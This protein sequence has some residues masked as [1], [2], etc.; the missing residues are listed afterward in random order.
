MSLSDRI[1]PLPSV[2]VA[3]IFVLLAGMTACRDDSPDDLPGHSQPMALSEVSESATL[4]LEFQFAAGEQSFFSE[5]DDCTA[6]D[7]VPFYDFDDRVQYFEVRGICDGDTPAQVIVGA[8][9]GNVPFVMAWSDG[10]SVYD[11]L[12]EQAAGEPF[13]VRFYSPF[14]II[15]EAVDS[16]KALAVIGNVDAEGLNEDYAAF[17]AEA[18]PPTA[19]TT[20]VSEAWDGLRQMA[21]AENDGPVLRQTAV[22]SNRISQATPRYDQEVYDGPYGGCYTGCGPVAAAILYGYWEERCFEDLIDGPWYD[23][24]THEDAD[25]RNMI[26]SLRSDLNSFCV[27]TWNSHDP[28]ATLPAMMDNMDEFGRDNGLPGMRVT[29]KIDIIAPY[30]YSRNKGVFEDHVRPQIDAGRPTVVLYHTNNGSFY[31]HYAVAEGYE[32]NSAGRYMEL[33]TGWGQNNLATVNISYGLAGSW[34]LYNNTDTCV[35]IGPV[36]EVVAPADGVTRQN[37][38][39]V[40]NGSATHRSQDSTALSYHWSSSLDGDISTEQS[41]S[42]RLSYGQHRITLQ[43]TDARGLSDNADVDITIE[44]E[45]PVAAIVSPGS[46]AVF[47]DGQTVEL[48]GSCSDPWDVDVLPSWRVVGDIGGV[49]TA[50]AETFSQ[51]LPIDD[52]T[53]TFTCTDEGQAFDTA[54]LDFEVQAEPANLPP[55]VTIVSPVHGTTFLYHSRTLADSI[56]F[57]ASADDSDGSI[58]S[59]S[60][61]AKRVGDS[62]DPVVFDSRNSFTLPLTDCS[63]PLGCP[64][65]LPLSFDISFTAVDNEGGTTTRTVRITIEYWVT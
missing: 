25:V 48:I 4:A 2:A 42:V 28:T 16:S 14:L 10:D 38:V 19:D 36:A 61:A 39:V 62:G 65:T 11:A 18:D 33:N 40:L 31:N 56:T 57:E 53:G 46:G 27:L 23:H 64:S 50:S 29:D 59:T 21:A 58:A 41:D 52:Y 17:L 15:G 44:N 45:D 34:S 3:A 32:I 20:H 7:A 22:T 30:V 1:L 8:N 54:S 47:Y 13:R 51:S 9:E 37:P 43:V 6:N 26:H 49:Y 24:Y 12:S 63:T 55:E 5:Y 35:P 60:W